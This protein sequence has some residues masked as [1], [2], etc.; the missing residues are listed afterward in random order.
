MKHLAIRDTR[1]V[2][3][4][5]DAT[6]LEDIETLES[7][8]LLSDFRL[9]PAE[10]LSLEL[11]GQ[12][13]VT[14]SVSGLRTRNAKLDDLGMDSVDFAGCELSRATFTGGKWSR[15]RFTD[16]KILS[17]QFRDLTFENVV[18]DH[19]KLD[20]AVFQAVTAK[21]PVIFGNCSLEETWFTGCDLSHVAF[22]E[23]RMVATS[24]QRSTCKG[25]DLRGNDLSRIRGIPSLAKAVIDPAQVVQLGHA[26]VIDLELR[27]KD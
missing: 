7:G 6:E 26:L 2:L 14:G 25:T 15:V 27:L 8:L 23:C 21:G 1:A 20:L 9:A 4:N 5:L 12:R 22:D 3:P 17:G 19:C 13:L 18:F 11:S 24:F 10:V 16:C